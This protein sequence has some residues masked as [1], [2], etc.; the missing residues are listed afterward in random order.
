M[1]VLSVSRVW[2]SRACASEWKGGCQQCAESACLVSASCFAK[3][4][5]LAGCAADL[6]HY[7]LISVNAPC[8]VR[9]T[10]SRGEPAKVKI[11]IRKK[12]QKAPIGYFALLNQE[13]RPQHPHGR[14]RSKLGCKDIVIATGPPA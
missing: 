11:K 12:K 7:S 3:I 6:V 10:V 5:L 2:R 13:H 9:V 4:F 1:Y 8:L 14:P